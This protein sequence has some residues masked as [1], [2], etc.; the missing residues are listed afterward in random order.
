M[1]NIYVK[2][3][4][5]TWPKSGTRNYTDEG[6]MLFECSDSTN[7]N[8]VWFSIVDASRE[9][10][11]FDR[12]VAFTYSSSLAIEPDYWSEVPSNVEESFDLVEF[13]KRDKETWP[14]SGSEYLT[15]LGW[16]Y[17]EDGRYRGGH[18][19]WFEKVDHSSP[20]DKFRGIERFW[21]FIATNAPNVWHRDRNFS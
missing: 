14:D 19:C 5:E 15:N 4:S 9:T 21:G 10:P 7:F 20:V 18:S 2:N 16:L 12:N 13:S 17:F 11:E 3:D 8:P 1:K 6:L